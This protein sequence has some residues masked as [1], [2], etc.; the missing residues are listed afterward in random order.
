M[1]F[2]QEFND[3]EIIKFLELNLEIPI[4]KNSRLASLQPLSE[5]FSSFRK[6]LF[7]L[8]SEKGLPEFSDGKKWLE[9]IG[10]ENAS[11][12]KRQFMKF[13]FKV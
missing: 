3:A 7:S 5:I 8:E 6:E 10:R 12:K 1:K 2:F 13:G 4:F 11:I 9:N